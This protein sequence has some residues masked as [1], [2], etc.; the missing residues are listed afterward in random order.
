MRAPCRFF[1]EKYY[2]KRIALT[3]F[4]ACVF[5]NSDVL[6]AQEPEYQKLDSVIIKMVDSTILSQNSFKAYPYAYYTPETEFAIGGGGIFIFYTSKKH[7][8]NPSKF[9][10]GG[11]WATTGQYHFRIDPVIFLSRNKL[12]VS[13]PTRYGRIVGKFWGIGNNTVETGNELYIREL[14]AS[15]LNIQ[16]KSYLF[17]A[18]RTGIIFD[19]NRTTIL[20]KR[21]N[22]YLLDDLV[23]GVEG[24]NVF[25]AGLG[26]VWDSRND[27]FYPTNGG[28]QYIKVMVYPEIDQEAFSYFELDVKQ[29]K[30]ISERSV[31]AG[32]FYAASTQGDAPFY[33]MPAL[34]GQNRMRG[35]F[36]GRY[37]D[38]FYMLFQL[39]YRHFFAKRFAY[40]LHAGAGDVASEMLKYS[41]HDIKFSY[42]GGLRYLFDKEK[43]VNLRFD[44]G[45]TNKGDVGVYFG[46]EEAF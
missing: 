14:I 35:F 34:G 24:G 39:E 41:S 10:F 19:F 29:Y 3:I 16:T 2:L 22:E 42:G 18:D 12:Y 28:Y 44:V 17:S 36:E 46:I 21:D 23:P 43:K 13:A 37:V 11:Y 27:F 7:E 6:Y 25:G 5:I 4:F 26:L 32:N 40:I 15:T 31:I 9:G 30:S 38:N 1:S 20:D 33:M 8:V 45:L